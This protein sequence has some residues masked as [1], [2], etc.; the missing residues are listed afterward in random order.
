[1]RHVHLWMSHGAIQ[2]LDVS[3]R[4]AD[5]S[6]ESL[7]VEKLVV[8]LRVDTPEGRGACADSGLAN[9]PKENGMGVRRCRR[10]PRR[11]ASAIRVVSCEKGFVALLRFGNEADLYWRGI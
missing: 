9:T 1:M 3:R 6:G 10:R 5:V 11:D 2:R 7:L 8:E 4:F